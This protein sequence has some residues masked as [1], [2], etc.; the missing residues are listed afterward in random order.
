MQHQVGFFG[1]VTIIFGLALGFSAPVALADPPDNYV[2][3]GIRAEFN[4]D[5]AAVIHA[6]VKVL[7]L[8]KFS[9]SGRPALVIGNAAELRLAATAE[10]DI[11]PR[12]SPYGGGGIAINKDGSGDVDP[13]LTGGLDIT[14][15]KQVV[16]QVGGN[17]IFSNNTDAELTATVNYA[18]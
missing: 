6:K 3:G 4:D 5:T 2:G 7:D 8:G 18:F 10:G 15:I 11:A 14:V 1:T 17:L 9:L 13:L 12:L 16:I